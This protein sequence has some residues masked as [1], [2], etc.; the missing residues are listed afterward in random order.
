MAWEE[1]CCQARWHRAYRIRRTGD[2]RSEETNDV[3]VE[4]RDEVRKCEEH[5]GGGVE[6]E[7]RDSRSVVE[8]DNQAPDD[9][10]NKD[11]HWVEEVGSIRELR[12]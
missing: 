6:E 10:S 8:E 4:T 1:H 3:L 2:G 7:D 9:R 5:G 11:D 12:W